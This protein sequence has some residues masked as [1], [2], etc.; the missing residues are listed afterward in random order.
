MQEI[1]AFL[2]LKQTDYCETMGASFSTGDLMATCA[3]FDE[4]TGS[5]LTGM[6][7]NTINKGDESTSFLNGWMGPMSFVPHMMLSVGV[8]DEGHCLEADYVPRGQVAFGSDSM[9]CETYFD[10]PEVSAW[11]AEAA[12]KGKH[13]APSESFSGRLLR[14]PIYIRV[15]CLSEGDAAALARAHASRWCQWIKDAKPSEARQ[16]GGLNV[17]DD[18]LRQYAFRANLVYA[19]SLTDSEKDARALAAGLTGPLA[20]AYIGGGS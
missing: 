14:S 16:R 19:K 10:N 9:Y 7:W 20:E 4:K 3:W 12:S 11:Y 15:G 2:D 1:S 13:M 17:R 5:K 6:S 8:N 18:K